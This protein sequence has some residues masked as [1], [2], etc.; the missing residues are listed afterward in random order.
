M[1]AA[2][3]R[4]TTSRTLSRCCSIQF[5]FIG[6]LLSG[7]SVG[8]RRHAAVRQDR[9]IGGMALTKECL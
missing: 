3:H 1:Q 5:S 2:M 7:V 8:D 4:R 6:S 9:Q